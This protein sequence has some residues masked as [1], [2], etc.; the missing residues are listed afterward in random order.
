VNG[1]G[2]VTSGVYWRQSLLRGDKCVPALLSL[3]G[4]RLTLSTADQPV[5]DTRPAEVTV[6]R[7]RFG[8]LVL[9]ADGASYALV[10][11]G[12]Q[13]SASFSEQQLSRL[14]EAAAAGHEVWLLDGQGEGR[15][16]PGL[17]GA[18]DGVLGLAEMGQLAERWCSLLVG[19]GARRA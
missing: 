4:G 14:R 12:A 8:T 7:T 16:A 1:S 9:R 10:G 2:P 15:P 6:K 5:L 18:V 3:E 19:R 17:D 11:R 13:I